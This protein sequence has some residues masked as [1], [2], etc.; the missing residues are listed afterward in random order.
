MKEYHFLKINQKKEY[1]CRTPLRYFPDIG[2]INFPTKIDY[3]IKL[4]LEKDIGKL[5]ESRKPLAANT[6]IPDPDAEI[7]FTRA[8]FV[9][10]EQILL[11]KNFRQHLEKIMVSKKILRM[12][13]QKT[14]IHKTYEIQKVLDSLNTEFLGA[15]RQFDWIEISFV[16]EKSDKHKTIYHSYN[17]EMATQ[18]I[19]SLKL[20]NFTELYSL[21][22][23]K[24]YDTDNLMHQHLLYKQFLAWSCN[25]SSVAP[26]SDY[27]DNPI[28]QEL[29]DQETY[30]SAKSKERIYLDL[31]ASCEFWICKRSRKT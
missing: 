1:I 2:K 29:P 23:E 26:V 24:K 27:I 22:N 31:R 20:T 9:Q 15:N 11:D 10:Y 13:A 8:P 18:L 4:F 16:P 25:G 17:R 5:F 21:T 30:F 6:A 12:G 19:K 3:R 7:I 14:P 28:F